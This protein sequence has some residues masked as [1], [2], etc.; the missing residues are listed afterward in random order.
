MFLNILTHKHI[1]RNDNPSVKNRRFLPAPFT[2]GSLWRGRNRYLFLLSVASRASGCPPDSMKRAVA[3][4]HTPMKTGRSYRPAS[5]FMQ[6][7]LRTSP[8]SGRFFVCNLPNELPFG[9]VLRWGVGF[10]SKVRNRPCRG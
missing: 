2:Q 8:E 6:F 7:P 3:R 10:G 1:L 5:G 4:T 9:Q